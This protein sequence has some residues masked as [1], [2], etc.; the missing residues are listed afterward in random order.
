MSKLCVVIFSV[1]SL[2]SGCGGGG[3]SGAPAAPPRADKG[4][5]PAVEAFFVGG[6]VRGLSDN[7]SVTV[8]NGTGALLNIVAN[9]DFKFPHKV[10]AG[11]TY[12][13]T[14]GA[15]PTG[16]VCTVG[17]ASGRV[18]VADVRGVDVMCNPAS[19]TVVQSGMAVQTLAGY[20]G[21]QG[22]GDG[23]LVHATFACPFGMALDGGG[24]LY[25]TDAQGESVRRITPTGTVSTL[26]AQFAAPG[27][28]TRDGFDNLY[29]AGPKSNL[30]HKISLSGE[31]S[32]FAN[33][34]WRGAGAMPVGI[35]ID[36]S[37]T[38]FAVGRETNVIYKISQLGVASIFAGKERTEGSIDGRGSDALF[39]MPFGVVL[40]ING[41][42]FV[43]DEGNHTIR[44]ITPDGMVTTVAG[45]AG[46]AGSADGA[47]SAARFRNPVGLTIDA[48]GNLYVVDSLNRTV[49]MVTPTGMVSTV[50]GTASVIG[51]TD[52]YSA[53][54]SFMDPY[55]IV[56]DGAG[57]LYVS[58]C[59][60][61]TIRT[62]TPSGEARTVSMTPPTK[63]FPETGV[64][65]T[66]AGKPGEMGS[67][68]GVGGDARFNNVAGIAVDQ[69]G[70]VIVGDGWPSSLL[71]RVTQSGVVTTIAGTKGFN[72]DRD[73]TGTEAGFSSLGGMTFD[74]EGNIYVGGYKTNGERTGL[75]RITPQ[76]AVTTINTPIYGASSFGALA[77]GP[78][79]LIYAIESDRVFKIA[80]SP[81]SAI[82]FAGQPSSG[83]PYHFDGPGG[84]ARFQSPGGIVVD[85]HGN[86]FVA[87]SRNLV[88]RKISPDGTVSTFA[89]LVGHAGTLP[90]YGSA[91]VDGIGGAARFHFPLGL[92]IDGADN[93]YVTDN[94][95][96]RKIT[97]NRM[98]TTVAGLA[99]ASGF[100]D[101]V[102]AA[103]RFGEL[104]AITVDKAGTI[105]VSDNKT[106]R[107]IIQK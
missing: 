18:E 107:K 38:M 12:S 94:N 53:A 31:V 20:A 101:G 93:L 37:G 52:G 97:P 19:T 69:T 13:V 57:K 6:T 28:I 17:A 78:A 105:Y 46:V 8:R 55:G 5:E 68:D 22:Q 63:V 102:G 81:L 41:N 59:G 51:S 30:I 77:T 26:V 34:G 72:T 39:R 50:A 84:L 103:A 29:V 35:A 4:T 95:T 49:R 88:I 62:L 82:V 14:I 90:G 1:I 2:V 91:T 106:I 61:H 66:L 47:G 27:G 56:V 65:T 70:N 44:K 73:G 74:A 43:S 9:G 40:D 32:T 71:R 89:G 16:Q 58:D 87:D 60:S 67:A 85:S 98:V 15:H 23:D 24:N 92:A 42:L 36:A 45:T 21:S 54:A 86:V 80:L 83:Y 75:R 33:L 48:T 7:R 3:S 99:G 104:H 96:I 25:V 11:T 76:G 100:A 64:V 79:G 10:N